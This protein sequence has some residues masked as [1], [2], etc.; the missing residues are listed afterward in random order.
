[1]AASPLKLTQVAPA[2]LQ[3]APYNPRTMSAE[4]YAALKRGI[5]EFGLVDPIIVQA[6]T[7]L[8]IGGHQ[9]L[10]AALELGLATVPVIALAGLS[11]QQ[12]ATLNVLLNNPAAQGEW[13]MAKLSAVLSELDA[14]GWDA[15]LTGFTEAALE[16][17]LTWAPPGEAPARGVLAQ[18]FGVV[19]FSVLDAR[20]GYWKERKAA[21]LALGIRSELGRGEGRKVTPGHNPMPM[22]GAR[23]GYRV[24][25]KAKRAQARAAR[26]EAAAPADGVEHVDP[27]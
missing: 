21:W 24:G 13:D 20:Q 27:A 2:S 26:A 12:V 17:I 25:A 3:P 5:G 16:R 6:E 11:E 15:T 8:V 18:R 10:R 9:R 7:R 22:K 19:P 23:E 1:M 14:S 4:A